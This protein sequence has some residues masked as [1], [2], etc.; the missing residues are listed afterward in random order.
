MKWISVKDR[1]PSF[2]EEVIVYSLDE[3]RCDIPQLCIGSFSERV[4]KTR[5]RN[6]E[7]GRW[8]IIEENKIIFAPYSTCCCYP[9]YVELECITH[10][11]PL[12]EEPEADARVIYD[13]SSSVSDEHRKKVK[14][15]VADTWSINMKK[16]KE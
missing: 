3:Y 15:A 4:K 2:N 11:M 7:T 16:D 1:L 14:E 10:W 9:G 5:I 6:Q 8:K 13:P 12:P